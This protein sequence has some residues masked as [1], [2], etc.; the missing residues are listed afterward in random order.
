[1]A[2]YTATN[3]VNAR[4]YIWGT[5]KP[6]DNDNSP[7]H[8]SEDAKGGQMTVAAINASVP[9][10]SKRTHGMRVYNQADDSYYKCDS[11]L[12]TFTKELEVS[13][14]GLYSYSRTS[15]SG[16]EVEQY[17]WENGDLEYFIIL[18]ERTANAA[19]GS[20]FYSTYPTVTFPTRFF[21][22]SKITANTGTVDTAVGMVWGEISSLSTTSMAL[23]IISKTNTGAG[24]MHAHVRGNWK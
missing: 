14:N 2:L 7:T 8:H 6:Y 3:A 19:S 1:M 21:D 5:I 4:Q 11:G 15:V 18:P 12:T 23:T 17:K 20:A 16:V 9:D 24:R 13:S 10:T 22:L